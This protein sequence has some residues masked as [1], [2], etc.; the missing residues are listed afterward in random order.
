MA[1]ISGLRFFESKTR[2][3]SWLAFGNYGIEM[4]KSF[5]EDS[6]AFFYCKNFWQAG[7]FEQIKELTSEQ[8]LWKPTPERHCIWEIV[9]HVNFWKS[10]AITYVVD[11]TKMNAKESNWAALPEITDEASWQN[12][13][14]N[15]KLI[16]ER[17]F[18]ISEEI[19]DSIYSSQE[20]K[21]IFFRQVL[22]HDSYHSG[23]IGLLRV[24]QGLNPVT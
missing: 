19:G 18:S 12:E 15:T 16:H 24:M 22:L 17:F 11:N 10:W 6:T 4:S 2:R 20:E 3:A 13:I 14:E 23:Q 7:F 8:A 5:L 21:I 9:R 1:R